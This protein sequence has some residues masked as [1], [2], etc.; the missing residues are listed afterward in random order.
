MSLPT[1]PDQG[2]IAIKVTTL[3]LRRALEVRLRDQGRI[4]EGG[5]LRLTLHRNGIHKCTWEEDPA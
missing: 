5:T 1:K 2:W 4:G 3:D